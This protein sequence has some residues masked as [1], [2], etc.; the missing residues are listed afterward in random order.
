MAA[1]ASAPPSPERLFQAMSAYQTTAAIKAAIEL[2]LFTAIAEGATNPVAIGAK[3]NGS[4]KGM[5]VLCDYLTIHGFLSKSGDQYALTQDSAIFLNRHS[6]AYMGGVIDFLLHPHIT[7]SFDNFGDVV[8]KGGT[9]LSAQGTMDPDHPVWQRFARAMVPMIMPSAEFI[10][11]VTGA[12]KGEPWKVLD[13]AAGHGMFGIT[14]GRRN[15]NAQ[16]HACDWKAVLAV[17]EEHAK[18]AGVTDRYHLMPG[19]AFDVDYGSGYD[20]VL[21]TNFFHH[22]DPPAC[23]RFM[24]KGLD[25]LRPGGRAVT[26]EFIPNPDRVSPPIAASF[27]MMMLGSVADGDAY[28]FAEYQRMFANAGYSSSEMLDIPMSPQR[29]VISYK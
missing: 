25:A 11:E 27:S 14:I 4:P 7:S 9:L 3:V 17:A 26:L 24:R 20:L 1:H 12:A 2:C 15:P 29:L 19:S 18:V 23:E 10:A 28:T 16:I 8:R 22:F 21:F 13:I 5:R 6:P